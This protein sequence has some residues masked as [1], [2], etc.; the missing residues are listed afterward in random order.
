MNTVHFN[1]ADLNLVK[2]LD[3]LARDIS[4]ARAARRLGVTPSAISH[5]STNPRVATR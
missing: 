5:V 3:A 2:V 4:V 1:D